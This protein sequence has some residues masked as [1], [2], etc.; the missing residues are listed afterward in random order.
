MAGSGVYLKPAFAEFI[1]SEIR[2]MEY[3]PTKMYKGSSQQRNAG[4]FR[5]KINHLQGVL[6]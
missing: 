3:G 1:F 4:V 6:P 5:E 2:F